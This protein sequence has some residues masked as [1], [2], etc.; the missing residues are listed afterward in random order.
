LVGLVKI[1]TA[2]N[3]KVVC[4]AVKSRAE[5][6]VLASFETKYFL[7][8]QRRA[9]RVLA[10]LGASCAEGLATLPKFELYVLAGMLCMAIA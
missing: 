9:Y 6:P 3:V 10:M 5:F 2:S 7:S 1:M 4:V 8:S